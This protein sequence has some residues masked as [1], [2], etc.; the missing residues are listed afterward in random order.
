MTPEVKTLL[1]GI[2]M[3]LAFSGLLLAILTFGQELYHSVRAYVDKKKTP[4]D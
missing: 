4:K 2:A 1:I 3:G